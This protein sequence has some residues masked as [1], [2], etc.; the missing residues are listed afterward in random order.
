M[1]TQNVVLNNGQQAIIQT[2]TAK[3]FIWANRTINGTFVNSTG[4]P[5]VIPA[6]Q[7]IGRIASSQNMA[8]CKSAASDGSQYPIG[9]LFETTTFAT[10]ETKQITI[11]N[12]G[13]VAREQVVFDGTDTFATPVLLRSLEDRI[14]GDTEGIHLVPTTE[15]SNYDNQ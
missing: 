5:L 7:V 10:G 4:S 11:C 15:L 2:S 3:I 8:I 1:S 6:G 12:K 14:T 9:L 13:D